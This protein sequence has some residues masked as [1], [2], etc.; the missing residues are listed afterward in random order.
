M[1]VKEIYYNDEFAKQ[2]KNLPKIIQKKAL[3]AEKFFRA[4]PF[5]PSIRLHKLQGKLKDYWSIS[6]DRKHRIIFLVEQNGNIIFISIGKHS[7]YE[8][9]S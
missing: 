3:K 5:H 7:I 2:F 9:L 1:E 4:N 6:L 8:D